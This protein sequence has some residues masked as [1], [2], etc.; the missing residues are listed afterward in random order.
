MDDKTRQ[1]RVL[2]LISTLEKNIEATEKYLR[3]I[4]RN[5]KKTGEVEKLEILLGSEKKRLKRLKDGDLSDV[6]EIEKRMEE[7][8]PQLIKKVQ[9]VIKDNQWRRETM[10]ELIKLARNKDR[11]KGK[12]E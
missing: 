12:L 9:D 3:E 7:E 4:R 11:K 6:Y 2:H 8:R 10:I 1:R 5:P